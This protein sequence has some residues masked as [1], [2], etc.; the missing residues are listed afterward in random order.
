MLYRNPGATAVAVLSL[1]LGIGANTAIFSLID[2]V[3]L[4]MLPVKNPEQLLF[5]GSGTGFREQSKV[6]GG[7]FTYPGY[8]RLRE[9]DH[10]FA[11]LA[12]FS[13]VR[14]NISIN[15]SREPS[16]PGQLVSGNYYGLLGVNAVAGRTLTSEDDRI[17]SGHPVAVISYGYWKRRFALDPSAIGRSIRIDGTPFTIVGVTPPDFF[18][19]EVGSSPDITVPIMMQPV[20]MPDTE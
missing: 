20:V 13:P 4:R 17:P 15:S 10:W 1:A 6:G 2:S 12:A 7:A 19:L 18:G 11:D 14:L 16:T 3:L 8:K 9:R 5:L